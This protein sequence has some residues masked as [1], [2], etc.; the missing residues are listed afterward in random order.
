MLHEFQWRV[1]FNMFSCVGQSSNCS[2]KFGWFCHH[3]SKRPPAATPAEVGAAGSRTWPNN[4]HSRDVSNVNPKWCNKHTPVV[5]PVTIIYI[6]IYSIYQWLSYIIPPLQCTLAWLFL[7][8]NAPLNETEQG[9]WHVTSFG[10]KVSIGC[11][12][13]LISIPRM[14]CYYPEI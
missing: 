13:W 1:W 10:R 7:G 8:A 6:Y 12:G 4:Y 5:T 11:T 3:H 9:R 14:P 2:R